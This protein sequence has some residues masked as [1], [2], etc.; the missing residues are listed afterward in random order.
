MPKDRKLALLLFVSLGINLFLGGLVGGR[1]LG[2]ESHQHA[3][4]E[5]DHPHQPPKGSKGIEKSAKEHP[6]AHQN[7]MLKG[8]G[9]P[10]RDRPEHPAGGP[11]DLALLR[12][13]IRIM[14]GP[15]D[16]RISELRTERREV[17][18]QVR[19]DMKAAHDRM[20]A[21]LTAEPHDEDE[22]RDALKNL[23]K[24]AFESQ[25]R[26]QEGILTLSRRMTKEERQKLRE[27]GPTRQKGRP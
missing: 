17:I 9:H 25:A 18:R 6:G 8:E 3:H 16:P 7:R 24:T 15:A 11:G 12:D 27:T 4:V 22:L 21:A 13:M 14:G 1:L 23:R 26:A 2:Q 5:A 10:R 20:R 19:T